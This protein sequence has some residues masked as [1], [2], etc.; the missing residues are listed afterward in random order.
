MRNQIDILSFLLLILSVSLIWSCASIGTPTGGPRDEE[1]PMVVRTNPPFG[2][3]GVTRQRIDI[4]FDEIVNV[5][6]AFSKVSVSPTSKS[7][8]RVSALEKTVSVVFEDSL[9]A[10]QTYTIDF[11]DCIED[12]NESNKLKNY[13][14]SFS[15]GENLDSLQISGIV[16]NARNLEPQQGIVV[17]VHRNFNDSAFKKIR[18]E[19]VTKTDDRGRF[20]LRNLKHKK[21]RLFALADLNNDY[22]WDNPAEDIAFFDTLIEP[23]HEFTSV[24]DTLWDFKTRTIDTVMTRTRTRFLPNDILLNSFN[25]DYKAQYLVDNKRIDSTRFSLIFNTIADTLPKVDLLGDNHPEDWYILERSVGNDTLTYWLKTDKLVRTDSLKIAATYLRTDS[26]QL[27]SLT[28]DTLKMITSRPKVK[29][30]KKK[31]KSD[32]N[33]TVVAPQIRFLT[34]KPITGATHEIYN[35]LIFEFDEPI[36]NI[37]NRGIRVEQKV[38]T[39]W[40]ACE[41]SD[42]TAVDSLQIRRFKVDCNWEFGQAYR[43]VADSTAIT[44][45]YG[46]FNKPFT[47]AFTVKKESDYRSLTFRIADLPDSTAAFVELLNQSDNV[48]NIAHVV[49][50]TAHFQYLPQN[51]YYA[52]LV[53]DRNGNG[54]FDTGSYDSLT[55]PENVY[56]YPKSIR[57]KRSDI[58]QEWKLNETPLDMQKPEKLK[59]NKPE[60]PKNKKRTTTEDVEE[61]AEGEEFFDVEANPFD[62]ESSKRRNNNSRNRPY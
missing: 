15:T 45:I 13:S 38:D 52:R 28:T 61:T 24:T 56:Y 35:P 10:G 31:K 2:A 57:L 44:G 26:A 58:S 17:G 23:H 41:H 16:L 8:P 3:T 20:T 19:R 51:T 49:D 27:L 32:D 54:K 7:V 18:L 42:L 6:D 55:Q 9:Q 30:E 39:L 33:D 22:R 60:Q 1:P 4:V 29:K 53:E 50:G 25:I 11:A 48:I 46:H 36:S 12:N 62:P 59:K 14:F 21:Y 43:L 40:K 37:D 5:K 47:H 34:I